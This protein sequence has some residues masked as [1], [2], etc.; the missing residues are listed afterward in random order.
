[1]RNAMVAGGAMTVVADGVWN[2]LNSWLPLIRAR[3]NRH[4]NAIDIE[5]HVSSVY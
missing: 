1:M 3:A 4:L 5:R 2:S